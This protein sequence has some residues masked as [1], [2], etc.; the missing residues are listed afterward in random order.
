MRSAQGTLRRELLDRAAVAAVLSGGLDDTARAIREPGSPG[1]W[2]WK[3]LADRIARGVF[4]GA[5]REIGVPVEPGFA[6]IPRDVK[7]L[8]LG[9]LDSAEDIAMAECASK[10]LRDLVA[11][12]DADF[13]KTKCENLLECYRQ[14]QESDVPKPRCGDLFGC[15]LPHHPGTE[16]LVPLLALCLCG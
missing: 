5:C 6:S 13:W 15:Q 4:L 9:R 7:M 10:E 16:L 12:H 14:R 8:I 2:L 3:R 1:Q 11:E